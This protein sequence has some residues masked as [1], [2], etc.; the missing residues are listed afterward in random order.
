MTVTSVYSIGNSPSLLSN[1]KDASA[2]PKDFL[3]CVPANITSKDFAPLRDF[4]L[5]SPSTHLIA[6]DILLFPEPLG[7]IAVV[8][9][10]LSSNIVLSAK[11]LNPCNSNLFKYIFYS[12][13]SIGT[14]SFGT[15]ISQKGQPSFIFYCYKFAITYLSFDYKFTIVH[16]YKISVT[17]F[18][19]TAILILLY[20]KTK[21]KKFFLAF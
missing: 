1:T 19:R 12:S 5:C 20:K 18:A 10:G 21:S 13:V 16:L 17:R 11:D 8:I 7:P 6:S 3:F 15:K 2:N 14:P 4:I 9:P